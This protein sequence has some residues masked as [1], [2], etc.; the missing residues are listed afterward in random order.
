[1]IYRHTTLSVKTLCFQTI[2]LLYIFVASFV[3]SFV[4][5]FGR[6]SIVTRI[7]RKRLE[8]FLKLTGNIHWP[9]LMTWLDFGGQRSRSQQAV[10][11]QRSVW[12]LGH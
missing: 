6:T 4:C 5:P 2:C 7:S 11:W 10:K 3:H 8:Q 1:M 12:M 9:L